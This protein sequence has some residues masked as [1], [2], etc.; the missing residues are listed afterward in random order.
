MP[1]NAAIKDTQKEA[2]QSLVRYFECARGDDGKFQL[3]IIRDDG[4]HIIGAFYGQQPLYIQETTRK[5]IQKAANR[6]GIEINPRE[7]D[8][9]ATEIIHDAAEELGLN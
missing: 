9:L 8:S 2:K 5:A 1:Q 3:S 6:H 4:G 7:I